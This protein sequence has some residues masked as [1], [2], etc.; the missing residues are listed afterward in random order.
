M[1]VNRIDR[2]GD[3]LEREVVKK[4]VLLSITLRNLGVTEGNS[5]V[6]ALGVE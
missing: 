3:Q 5:Q 6:P 2:I 4:R 1:S